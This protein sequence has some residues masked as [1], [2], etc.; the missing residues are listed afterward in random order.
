[1]AEQEPISQPAEET[2]A[3][4]TPPSKLEVSVDRAIEVFM[5]KFL[6]N[7]PMSRDTAAWN[8]FYEHLPMLKQVL[9]EE[10]GS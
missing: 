1:M 3:K 4:A 2:Q 7:S 10:I 6:R 9:I 5:S 8:H